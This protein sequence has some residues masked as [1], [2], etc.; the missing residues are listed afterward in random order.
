MSPVQC[1]ANFATSDNITLMKTAYFDL[2]IKNIPNM[3]IEVIERKLK[4]S[5]DINHPWIRGT[6]NELPETLDTFNDAPTMNT[7]YVWGRRYLKRTSLR[8]IAPS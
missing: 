4:S 6:M 2:C 7:R 1:S 5:E 3:Q 8:H